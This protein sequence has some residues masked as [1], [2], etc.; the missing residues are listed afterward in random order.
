MH[1]HKVTKV[2]RKT[3]TVNKVTAIMALLVKKVHKVHS[4]TTGILCTESV[5]CSANT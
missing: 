1:S 3:L 4:P 5:L 2:H